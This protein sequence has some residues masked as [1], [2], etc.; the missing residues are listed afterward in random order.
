[1]APTTCCYPKHILKIALFIAV[2]E[3]YDILVEV[4]ANSFTEFWTM[5]VFPGSFSRAKSVQEFDYLTNHGKADK[6]Q[7][8]SKKPANNFNRRITWVCHALALWPRIFPR[9]SPPGS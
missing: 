5:N 8:L 9:K 2:A 4:P 7:S 1:M 3:T 6:H